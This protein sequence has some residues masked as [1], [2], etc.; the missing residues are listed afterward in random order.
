MNLKERMILTSLKMLPKNQLS[1]SIGKLTSIA[2]PPKMMKK[3]ILMFA[4]RY[5]INLSEIEKPLDEYKTLN[6]F[7]TRKL[8]DGARVVNQDNN[9]ITSPSDGLVSQFGEIKNGKLIQVKGIDYDLKSLLQDGKESLFK[10]GYY[11]TIYLSPKDYHRVHSPLDGIIKEAHYIKGRLFP[12]NKLSVE[13]IN[14]LFS[15]NERVN[16]Y[17]ENK[18]VGIFSLIFVGATNVGSISLSF[19]NLKTN[20]IFQKGVLK[21]FNHS[22]KKGEELGAFNFGSTVILLFQ[23]NSIKNFLITTEKSVEM[24]EVVGTLA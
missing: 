3:V 5:G 8:K 13:N 4:N 23:K 17:I 20:Q 21:K 10:D 16:L 12:V 11:I 9:S 24:G 15:T 22:V 1:W 6:Q 7:F 2:L 18:R 19:D 14:E